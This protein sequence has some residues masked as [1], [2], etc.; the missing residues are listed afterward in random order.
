MEKDQEALRET[1][2]ARGAGVPANVRRRQG[3]PL[4]ER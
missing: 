4:E 1:Y 3:D 2:G